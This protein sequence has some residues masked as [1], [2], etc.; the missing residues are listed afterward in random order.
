MSH[1]IAGV[2]V[3]ALIS[4]T[5]VIAGTG[6]QVQEPRTPVNRRPTH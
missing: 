5:S 6:R 1:F 4:P 2:A 3:A